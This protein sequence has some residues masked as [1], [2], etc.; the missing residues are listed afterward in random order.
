MQAV[1]I[2]QGRRRVCDRCW[3]VVPRLWVLE[4]DGVVLGVYCADCTQELRLELCDGREVRW[5][6]Y[7]FPIEDPTKEVS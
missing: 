5:S 7:L 2:R 3:E 6:R 1:D 4:H